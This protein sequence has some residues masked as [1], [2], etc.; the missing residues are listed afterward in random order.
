MQQNAFPSSVIVADDSS[1]MRDIL[2]YKLAEVFSHVHLATDGLE[3]VEAA[4]GLHAALVILDYRMARLNGIEACRDIRDLP[5]Y[6]SVPIVLL[7]AYDDERLR[8]DAARSGVTL[9]VPK[10]VIYE[11]LMEKLAP[12]LK[13]GW[14]AAPVSA[15]D[16]LARGRELLNQRRRIEAEVDNAKRRYIGMA[17]RTTPFLGPWRR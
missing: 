12:L 10:P 7:T 2:R 5:G 17:E 8:R 6:E 16:G 13:A 14:E 15:T 3:A 1:L 9:V 4:R 11:Q